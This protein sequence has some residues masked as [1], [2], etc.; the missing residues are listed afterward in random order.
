MWELL[1][2]LGSDNFG[3]SCSGL[4]HKCSVLC[5]SWPEFNIKIARCQ[6]GDYSRLDFKFPAR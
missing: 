4:I 6:T 3:V 5:D 2:S 1:L